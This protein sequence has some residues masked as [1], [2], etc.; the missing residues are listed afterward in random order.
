MPASA[1]GIAL[2]FVAG[3]GVLAAIVFVAYQWGRNDCMADYERANARIRGEHAETVNA[4][5][6][7]S[8]ERALDSQEKELTNEVRVEAIA[9]SAAREPAALDECIS[10]DVIDELRSLQ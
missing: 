2:R 7:A 3:A 5:E 1:L 10:V 4:A 6:R 9:K 8:T